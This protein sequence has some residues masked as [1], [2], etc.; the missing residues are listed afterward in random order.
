MK[1]K[2]LSGHLHCLDIALGNIGVKL[3]NV[4]IFINTQLFQ[5]FFF[6]FSID[7]YNY[8][9]PRWVNIIIGLKNM[10]GRVY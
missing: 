8:V 1:L 2:L 5:G 7:I 10:Y 6:T 3:F 9:H 4:F